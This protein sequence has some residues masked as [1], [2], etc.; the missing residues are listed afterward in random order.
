MALGMEVGLGPGHIVLDGEPAPLLQKGGRPPI[1]G[2]FF[3]SPNGWIPSNTMWPE[4]RST[5]VPSGVFIHPVVWP[6]RTLDENWGL[7]PFRGGE[8]GSRSNKV[9]WAEAYR[10]T[11]WHPDASSR[12]ATIKMD[13]KLGVCP[14]MGRGAGSPC[15][16][17]WPGP[18]PTSM[19]SAILVHQAV[20]P[21]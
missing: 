10:H 18:R 12:L 7:C 16:T 1:F 3:L 8:A 9:A 5:S 20:R 19:P 15:S 14:F 21:Q 4:P 13:R 6:Q 11:K 17:M 2:P